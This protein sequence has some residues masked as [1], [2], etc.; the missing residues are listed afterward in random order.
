M[1]LLLLSLVFIFSCSGISKKSLCTDNYAYYQGIQDAQVLKEHDH[2]KFSICKA[3][4]ESINHSYT[5]GY[6]SEA[7]EEKY[8]RHRLGKRFECS[9]SIFNKETHKGTGDTM[10][11]AKHNVIQHCRMTKSISE[12]TESNIVC[13]R[14]KNT[15]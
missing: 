14:L 4:K 5:K 11:R 8:I 2:S 3:N 9:Y 6:Y 10:A 12:C 13:K 15:F 7:T 1:K